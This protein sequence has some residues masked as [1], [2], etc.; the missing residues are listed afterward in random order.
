MFLASLLIWDKKYCNNGICVY[1]VSLIKLEQM[2]IGRFSNLEG[3]SGA[4]LGHCHILSQKGCM[5]NN[6]QDPNNA[7]T[8]LH[9]ANKYLNNINRSSKH[10][11]KLQVLDVTVL[12]QGWH[13]YSESATE[14]DTYDINVIALVKGCFS[15]N[16][17]IIF[18]LYYTNALPSNKYFFFQGNV[19]DFLM[20]IYYLSEYLCVFK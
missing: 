20:I 5:I 3:I 9:M 16:L 17:L 12:K 13:K 7:I 2:N 19:I 18:C 15:K 4:H 8:P 11:Q 10:S 1:L 14:R 6:W